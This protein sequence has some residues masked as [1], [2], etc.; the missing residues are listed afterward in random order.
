MECVFQNGK[1]R[2]IE[3][4]QSSGAMLKS[5]WAVWAVVVQPVTI[6]I[7]SNAFVVPD[8]SQPAFTGRVLLQQCSQAFAVGRGSGAAINRG[9][10]RRKAEEMNMVII[11]PWKQR[12][13]RSLHNGFAGA[14]EKATDVGNDAPIDSQII[15]ACLIDFSVLDQHV[16]TT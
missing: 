6:N 16:E 2:R 1:S 8:H 10:R 14:G 7:A 15:Q 13:T 5:D 4:P 11:E 12:A 9:Q 3:N